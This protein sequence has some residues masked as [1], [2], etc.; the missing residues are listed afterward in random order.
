MPLQTGQILNNRYRIVKKMAEGGFGAVYRAYDLAIKR[1]CALKENFETSSQAQKQFEREAV[2]LANLSHPNLPRVTDHFV[3]PGQGQYLVMDFVEGEDLQEKLDRVGGPLPESQVMPWIEQVC[4]ALSCL[5][6]Q[7]S[8]IIHRDVKPANI[9]ITADGKAILVDFG[10]AKAYD[11]HLKTT[12]GARA[13]T[14]GYSP[15]EQYGAG[16]TDARSDVY[17][18]GATLYALLTGQQPPASTDRAAG[19]FLAPPSSLNPGV[20]P[21]IEIA[22][23]KAMALSQAERFQTVAEFQSALHPR[24]KWI[25]AIL[26][27]LAVSIMALIVFSL[28][29]EPSPDVSGVA[30]PTWTEDILPSGTPVLPTNPA[31][32][33][34]A[35][36]QSLYE[37]QTAVA[38]TGAVTS[39]PSATSTPSPTPAL[40]IGDTLVSPKDGMVMMYVPAG[41]FLMGL[42]DSQIDYVQA[43]SADCDN[44]LDVSKP[45]HTV[46]LDAYW[47]YK[48]EVS[49]AMYQLCVAEG[50]CAQPRAFRSETRS[51][52][53]LNPNYSQY[54]VVFVDWDDANNYCRWAGGRLSTEAEWEKA[55]RGTDGRLFPW[56][57][58]LPNSQLANIDLYFGDTTP[59]NSFSESENPYGVLNMAGNVYEWVAD[60]YLS[61]YYLASP[62]DNP[63]GPNNTSGVLNKRVVRGGNWGWDTGCAC[64]AVH[65]WWEYYQTDSGVGFRCVM[66]VNR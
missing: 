41:E 63:V 50:S 5:H 49:N 11:P 40:T 14:P 54:P 24:K 21:H 53:Y 4:D 12:I 60:W 15:P 46:N 19:V 9:K 62:Y 18:L 7:Q 33:A 51:D 47:I 35:T 32:K 44:V 6:D 30:S 56:G 20:S 59:V 61:D 37:T 64:I 13:V 31:F 38:A 48:T 22:I 57:N 42:T 2:M 10:I 39:I 43:H 25:W 58:Q 1:P 26:A 29:E 52:Y 27:V 65:D 34:T 17:A 66:D 36:I 16:T 8:P 3:I 23:E 28:W 45:Q 55:A